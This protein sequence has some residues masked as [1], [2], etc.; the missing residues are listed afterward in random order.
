MGSRP[1]SM[2]IGL[3]EASQRLS[4]ERGHHQEVTQKGGLVWF[5]CFPNKPLLSCKL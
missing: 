3:C 4:Q 1:G 5:Q 2:A